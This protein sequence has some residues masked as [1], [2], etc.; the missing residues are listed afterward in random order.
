MSL[1]V[2]HF[3]LVIHILVMSIFFC[4]T[5]LYALAVGIDKHSLVVLLGMQSF[6][7]FEHDETCT[8]SD[9]HDQHYQSCNNTHQTVGGNE[10]DDGSSC[11]GCCPIDVPPLY[12]HEFKGLLESLEQWVIGVADFLIFSCH[13]S[14]RFSLTEYARNNSHSLVGHTE[15]QWQCLCCC[16][17]ED[18]CSY[19][20]H[21]LFLD[22]LLLIVHGDVNA[23]GT[24]Y[25][26]N[27][28]NGITELDHNRHVFGN[29]LR[30]TQ[31]CV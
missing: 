19:N 2:V 3:L 18:T 29:F 25:G 8:R 9:C 10:A 23:D 20:H 11:R 28:C 4:F 22:I 7:L 21:D 12:S 15:E 14:R 6:P 1:P 26:N 24:H 17:E 13:S 16:H 31:D 27:T 30:I 5:F